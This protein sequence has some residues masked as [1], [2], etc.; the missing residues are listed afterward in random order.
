V[1][2][3]VEEGDRQPAPPALAETPGESADTT[4]EDLVADIDGEYESTRDGGTAEAESRSDTM[5]GAEER[6]VSFTLSG[7]EY[8]VP[9]GSVVEV[10]RP[11]NVTPLPHVPDWLIG[12]TNLRG[13]VVSLVN[14]RAFLG[15]DSVEQE[16]SGRLLVAR[17]QDQAV[18]MGFIVDRV[19]G[20]RRISAD[21]I[22][23]PT[24][25]IDNPVAPFVRGVSEFD[26]RLLVVLDLDKLLLSHEMQQFQAV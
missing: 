9:M 24:A 25:P 13:D 16:R 17:S 26:H 15:L 2:A 6:Y 19:N 5:V 23:Q 4:L 21:R 10:G 3:I 1:P 22:S 18:A 20:I 14:L 8:A 12:V 7:T 11:P